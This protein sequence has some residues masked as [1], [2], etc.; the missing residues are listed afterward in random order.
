VL[1]KT[2]RVE[3]DTRPPEPFVI[4]YDVEV[5][6]KVELPALL[7]D[8]LSM[9]GV[10]ERGT[11][12]YETHAREFHARHNGIPAGLILAAGEN[13]PGQ[14]TAI[15]RLLECAVVEKDDLLALLSDPDAVIP[16]DVFIAIF[17][18]LNEL[19]AGRPTTKP[20]S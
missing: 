11:G 8:P 2:F 10:E 18:W 5:K 19:A 20:S 13:G 7:G 14:A 6:E 12:V 9:G 1:V 4:E 3:R 17:E 16:M 15:R